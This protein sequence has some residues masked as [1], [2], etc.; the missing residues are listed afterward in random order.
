MI[1]KVIITVVTT[2]LTFEFSEFYPLKKFGTQSNRTPIRV[3]IMPIGRERAAIVFQEVLVLDV[4]QKPATR[5]VS[6][7]SI[8]AI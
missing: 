2:S 4:P 1:T 3:V 5:I 7:A 8:I 6:P